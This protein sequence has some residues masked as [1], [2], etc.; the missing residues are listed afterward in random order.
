MF[1]IKYKKKIEMKI[2]ISSNNEKFKCID[3]LFFEIYLKRFEI[4]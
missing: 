4:K 1:N 2:T 3:N